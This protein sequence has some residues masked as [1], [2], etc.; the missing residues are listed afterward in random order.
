M[1]H[2]VTPLRCVCV[3]FACY[4]PFLHPLFA[5]LQAK[6]HPDFVLGMDWSKFI[7]A[8]DGTTYWVM[9]LNALGGM[10]CDPSAKAQPCSFALIITKDSSAA[11]IKA[12][13]HAME[14]M[15]YKQ[16]GVLSFVPRMVMI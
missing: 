2:A 1:A 11:C 10:R 9:T 8:E 13:L 5:F 7:V 12:M 6:K 14:T 16:H 15:Q 4:V 3:A